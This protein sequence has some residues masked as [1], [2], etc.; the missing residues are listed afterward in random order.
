[1]VTG[2]RLSVNVIR[3]CPLFLSLGVKELNVCGTAGR[4]H[5]VQPP[6]TIGHMHVT[7]VLYCTVLYC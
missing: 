4:T 5:R 7:E 6:I 1:M 2:T 3:T